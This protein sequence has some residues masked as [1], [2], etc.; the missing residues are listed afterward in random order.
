MRPDDRTAASTSFSQQGQPVCNGRRSL[1]KPGRYRDRSADSEL[2][3]SGPSHKDHTMT[4]NLLIAAL[5][6]T[7]AAFSFAQAPAKPMAP[8]GA[9]PMAAA[10]PA[11]EAKPMAA[12]K[13]GKKKH[14]KAAKAAAAAK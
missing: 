4:K 14:K 12:K 7:S 11:A 10:A 1:H 9:A 5:L 3:E 8:A 6:S 2:L 13:A